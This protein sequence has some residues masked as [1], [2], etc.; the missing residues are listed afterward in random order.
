M[1]KICSLLLAL[2]IFISALVSCDESSPSTG[3]ESKPSSKPA[4][5]PTAQ[6]SEV[7]SKEPIKAASV[8]GKNAR[9]LIESAQEY[10]S[11]DKVT[12]I[13]LSMTTTEIAGDT[14]LTG[15]IQ[16]KKSGESMYVLLDENG[17]KTEIWI[18]NGNLYVNAGGVKQMFCDMSLEDFF[19]GDLEDL[20]EDNSSNSQMPEEKLDAAEIYFF[21]NEYY[22]SI[23]LTPEEAEAEGLPRE[24][25]TMT[26]YFD[27][28]GILKRAL[29]DQKSY[30]ETLELAVLNKPV[31]ISPPEDKE[32][33]TEISVEVTRSEY[34]KYL[35]VLDAIEKSGYV[36]MELYYY[37]DTM[38]IERVCDYAWDSKG[39]EGTYSAKYQ[40][41]VLKISDK[42]YRYNDAT[43]N[44]DAVTSDADIA[45]VNQIIENTRRYYAMAC[46]AIPRISMSDFSAVD[47]NGSTVISFMASGSYYEYTVE[48]DALYVSI[49]FPYGG[50]VGEY[51]FEIQLFDSGTVRI[52]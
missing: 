2:V 40:T 29:Q 20:L 39:N 24:S 50:G 41:T 36:F 37:S 7:L 27:K 48:D 34:Q 15:S 11:I 8:N 47:E 16:I 3:D 42:H 38:P 51:W 31:R 44:F 18:A 43:E 28:K 22:F 52:P 4:E 32:Q 19:E 14:I 1:R 26:F 33:Y 13:D 17:E 10:M 9:Q 6:T 23:E 25:C 49:A 45:A 30:K 12:D 35:G 21:G 5:K 46:G